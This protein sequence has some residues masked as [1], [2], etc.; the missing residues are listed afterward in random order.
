MPMQKL[1]N[2]KN[3]ACSK[4]KKEIKPLKLTSINNLD[5]N[6]QKIRNKTRELEVMWK[7][8]MLRRS[9]KVNKRKKLKEDLMNHLK[10]EYPNQNDRSRPISSSYELA[11]ILYN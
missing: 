5:A 1:N 10:I 4:L 3:K 2:N 8:Y 11:K 7:K 9:L 6:V